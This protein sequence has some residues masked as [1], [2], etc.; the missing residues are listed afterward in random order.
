MAR[1]SEKV[2]KTETKI[3]LSRQLTKAKDTLGDLKKRG[4]KSTC[5]E[6]GI[7]I[8]VIP[9]WGGGLLNKKK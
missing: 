1:G 6:A 4:L 3:D 2:E 9:W 5:H 8:L 7:N